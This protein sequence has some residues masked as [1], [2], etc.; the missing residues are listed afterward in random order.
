MSKNTEI[1]KFNPDE[2][3]RFVLSGKV[4][5]DITSTLKEVEE[6]II[7]KCKSKDQKIKKEGLEELSDKATVVMRAYENETRICLAESVDKEY[8]GLAQELSKEIQKDYNCTTSLE[9]SMIGTIVS[10]YIRT[11]DNSKRLNNEL[12]GKNIT[13][14]RNRYI[15]N[16]SVQVDRA[17]R[18]FIQSIL[19]LKQ[20]K[21]P[22]LGVSIK[23]KNAYISQNQQINNNKENNETK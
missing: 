11:I 14:E 10:A 22:T 17:N 16:L 12:N 1:K 7:P 18:Q 4:G 3:K 21:T 13:H 23:T 15:S 6:K 20:L 8:W 2:T 19:A 5:V 9:K